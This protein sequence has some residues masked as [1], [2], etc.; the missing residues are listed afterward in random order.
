MTR[1]SQ[2]AACGVERYGGAVRS[3]GATYI[4]PLH[5]IAVSV[6]NGGAGALEGTLSNACGA[7]CS[8]TVIESLAAGRVH[9]WPE[10]GVV[11]LPAFAPRCALASRIRAASEPRGAN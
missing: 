3:G 10:P 4:E 9:T 1:H 6:L 8:W 5:C 7:R 11:T 2:R